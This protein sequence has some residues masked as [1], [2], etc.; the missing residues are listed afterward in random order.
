MSSNSIM[1]IIFYFD[2]VHIGYQRLELNSLPPHYP[3]TSPAP[4]PPE[5]ESTIER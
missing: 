1:V 4:C 5:K 3:L 2:G